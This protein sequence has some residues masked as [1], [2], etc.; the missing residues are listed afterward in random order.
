MHPLGESTDGGA[1]RVLYA[2]S[3]T[4]PILRDVQGA[5]GDDEAQRGASDGSVQDS[6]GRNGGLSSGAVAGE[7][8]EIL[9]GSFE[10]LGDDHLQ[11]VGGGGSGSD[12]GGF[13]GNR[14]HR[15]GKRHRCRKAGGSN[16]VDGASLAISGVLESACRELHAAADTAGSGDD[17]GGV[18]AV[19]GLPVDPKGIHRGEIPFGREDHGIGHAVAVAVEHP[20]AQ[21]RLRGDGDPARAGSWGVPREIGGIAAQANGVAGYDRICRR[22]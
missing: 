14:S 5:A 2:G 13:H 21:M 3:Q 15:V 8:Y 12:E 4:Q 6:C 7:T 17:Q 1:G 10:A 19:I 9:A 20:G 16:D 18:D 11:G 22:I